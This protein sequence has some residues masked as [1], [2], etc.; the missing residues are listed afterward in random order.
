M[1]NDQEL[2]IEEFVQAL[3]KGS[4]SEKNLSF[5]K[6]FI[7]L[8]KK[9]IIMNEKITSIKSRSYNILLKNNI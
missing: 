1:E 6:K 3:I 7:V 2:D 9:I 5:S 8:Y 4:V